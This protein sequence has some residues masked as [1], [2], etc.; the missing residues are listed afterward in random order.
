MEK[1]EVTK[2]RVLRKIMLGTSAV[3][4]AV[5]LVASFDGEAQSSGSGGGGS[6]KPEFKIYEESC[7]ELIDN[8]WKYVGSG[9]T[10]GPGTQYC[11]PNPCG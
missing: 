5:G 8:E 6:D 7:Y 11:T 2:S 1:S 4:M 3:V 9:N 10:C